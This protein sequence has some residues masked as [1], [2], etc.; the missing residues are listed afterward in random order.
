MRQTGCSCPAYA[1]LLRLLSGQKEVLFFIGSQY[2]GADAAGALPIFLR[3]DEAAK[4]LAFVRDT[5][6]HLQEIMAHASADVTRLVE[7]NHLTP[8]ITFTCQGAGSDRQAQQNNAGILSLH[9]IPLEGGDYTLRFEYAANKFREDTV[10]RMAELFGRVVAGLC[11]DQAL[12]EIPLVSEPGLQE[13][14]VWNATEAP[15]PETDVVSLFRTAAE[16]YADRT[17]VVFGDKSLSYREVDECSERIA[18]WLRA[19]GIG[20]GD[21]VSVLIPRCEYMATVSLGVLKAGAAYQPLDPSYPSERLSFMMKDADCKLL[22]ADEGLL[23]KV[24]DYQGERLLTR[25]IPALPEC[26][27]IGECPRPEDLFILLYTSGSTGTPKGVMLEHGNLANFCAFYRTY[28]DLTPD[29]R[30]AAYASYG[31]DA[32]MMDLYPALTSGAA[33]CIVDEET[34]LD[35]TALEAW[36]DR[37]GITHAFITTQMG[38]QFYTLADPRTL[39]YLSVGGEKLVPLPPKAGG[40]RFINAYGPTECTIFSTVMPVDRLYERVPI[41]KPLSN[42]KCYVVDENLR[43]LPPLVPG[44]LLI[45]GRGVGRGYLNRPDLSEK[46]F[47]QNPFCAEEG[48]ERAYRTG[49]TARL[50]PDGNYDIL[51]RSDGQVKARGFRIELSEV[52]AVIR[53]FP[54]IYDA[55]VQAFED[56]NTGEKY[57]AAYVVSDGKIDTAML[58]GFIR[59]RKPAYMVPSVIMQIDAIPL[60]QNQKVNRKAL[61]KPETQS[62]KEADK[63]IDNVLEIEMKKVVAEILGERR[64]SFTTPL[65]EAGMSSIGFIRLAAFIYKRFGIKLPVE[66]LKGVSML[67]LENRLLSMWMSGVNHVVEKVVAGIAGIVGDRRGPS[68]LSA[69]QTG[70][71]M[72][73]VKN[74][75]STVYN[76]PVMLTFPS[77]TSPESL[78]RAMK[79]VMAAHPSLMVHFKMVDNQIMTVPNAR[80][81]PEIPVLNMTEAEAMEYA[82]DF[83]RPFDLSKENLYAFAVTRTKQAV[84]L[85]MNFQHLI[86]DGFTLNLFLEALGDALSGKAIQ[87]ETADYAEYVRDQQAMMEGEKAKEYEAY[88][89]K[90]FEKYDAPTR[91]TPDQPKTDRPG[92]SGLV[93]IP[94][95]QAATDQALRRTNVSEAAFYLA[96]LNYTVA[97]L[98]NSDQVYLSTIS[99]GRSDVRFTDTYGMFVNTL[100]LASDLTPGSVDEYIQKTADD[101]RQAIEHE[102]YPFAAVASRW[103]YSVEL[104]YAYQRDILQKPR[105]PGLVSMEEYSSE[106]LMFPLFV[107]I[108]DDAGSPMIE[109]Q[110]DDSLY[111]PELAGK[112]GRFMNT[113]ITRFSEDGNQPLRR[114]SLLDAEEE[115]R[116]ARLRTEPETVEVPEDTFFFT[117]LERSAAQYPDRTAVIAADGVFTYWEFDEMTDRVANALIKRGAKPGGKVLVLL[118]R[119]SRALTAFFGASKAGLAYIPFDPAYPVDRVNMVI[120]DSEAQFVITNAEMLPRFE[121]RNAI[122]IEELLLETDAAKPQVP[123]KPENIS[124]MIFTSGSTGRPKGVMLTHRAMA[125]YVADMP[126]KEMVN[127]VRAFCSV[128]CS[129]TTLS[130]DVSVMEYNMT[131]SHGLTLVLASEAEC[132][133]PDKLARR[134]IETHAD[135]ISGTPSRI[136]GLLRSDAFCDALSRN[137][138]LVICGGEKYPEQLMLKLKTLV[139]H[140]I[141][142]YGPSE[143]TISCNEHELTNDGFVSLGR[144]TPGVTEYIVDTDGNELPAGLVGELWIGGRGVGLGYNKLPEMTAER[145]RSCAEII[146]TECAG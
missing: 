142:I 104:M 134:M 108:V 14:N 129:I 60:T 78:V 141:N 52:E 55:T 16:R 136:Y 25:N 85:L 6:A 51:G 144:P 140:Q 3:I 18:G 17:A 21:V 50:L 139:P 84:R 123:L 118:P 66:N 89:A 33:V 29:S 32:C 90:I 92:E 117:G 42:Y 112:I 94:V 124:Y 75:N 132:N 1:Y 107:R 133:D 5:Q 74:P 125:H 26:E 35:L 13:M 12:G 39:K 131:L 8:D 69:S 93:R 77:G 27:G 143:I 11:A 53:D 119:N 72:E 70:V 44:E 22:V 120:E 24:P 45:A 49:D 101:L 99:S 43:R 106:G 102:N 56:E 146:C 47:I 114:I 97:R 130:F 64:A 79:A 41:G 4:G 137:V 65:E 23:D 61:P 62:A 37:M 95:S 7:E 87:H 105:I 96:A 73:C 110:Y 116:L 59:E 113:V 126:G 81:E 98:T 138:Q 88:F 100:P 127:M 91:I 9:L 36:F 2:Q 58:S 80:T 15:C 67:D 82:D 40:L 145:F 20:R 115:A 68:P 128:Y 54:G 103:N 63:R 57:I 71:Y 30:V 109:V 135:L 122:D 10:R 46:A 34:R 19:R 76:I 111:S 83:F 86:V 121:G 48:Y 31:F 28:Y 38:R